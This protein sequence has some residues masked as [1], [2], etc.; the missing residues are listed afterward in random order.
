L[1]FIWYLSHL[2]TKKIA[3]IQVRIHLTFFILLLFSLSSLAAPHFDHPVLVRLLL[4]FHL[5]RVYQVNDQPHLHQ[6]FHL[7][8]CVSSYC[9]CFISQNEVKF[10]RFSLFIKQLLPSLHPNYHW[11]WNEQSN[12]SF[13]AWKFVW[14]KCSI[15]D[16]QTQHFN[17]LDDCSVMFL[18]LSYLN[19]QDY[20]LE[21]EIT[22]S[23]SI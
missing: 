20:V 17:E 1:H 12:N 5:I 10:H 4:S 2:I 16:L 8:L 18:I 22:L 23:L 3:T 13:V 7:K 6:S 11:L 19:G 21:V 14:E 9:V 15:L